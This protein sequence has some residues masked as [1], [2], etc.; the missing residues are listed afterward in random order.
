MA[1]ISAVDVHSREDL[2]RFVHD[3]S[4]LAQT[5]DTNTFNS[6]LPRY[7]EAM[8]AW[9]NDMPGYFANEKQAVPDASW[10]LFAMILEA[11]LKY[12]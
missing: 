12:E 2:I 9:I 5:A 3:L 7:L 6:E 4:Q 11:A 1:S 8:S 10:M